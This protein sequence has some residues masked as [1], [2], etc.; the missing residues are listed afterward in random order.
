MM[1]ARGE[2]RAFETRWMARSLGIAALTGVRRARDAGGCW[3][4]LRSP[5]P[6][7]RPCAVGRR[8]AHLDVCAQ[9]A[10][11]TR[12]MPGLL[13]IAALTPTYPPSSRCRASRCSPRR[14]RSTASCTRWMP[15]L[16]G[17]AAL[18]PTYPP[19]SRCRASR[20]SP[21][22]VRS[23]ASFTRWM[24]GLLGIA[25]L[26]PTYA[27]SSRCRASRCSPRRVRSTASF[28]R[29]MP[30]LLG[31]AALTPT[32]APSLRCR[33]SRCSPRR[34]RSRGVL[35]ALDAGAVGHRCAHPN[36]RVL[37]SPKGRLG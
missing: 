28:T 22:R 37:T 20:C 14:V 24:P 1:P 21:R 18:T 35:Y 23:T 16:L 15:G 32:Y 36:L 30:G 2:D 10:S 26:T 12:W 34:V 11:C 17:I 27:P 9:R 33:A 8:G 19:S 13:G 25:A 6:T 31:I 7:R 3:A 29:W 5:Q 4:S